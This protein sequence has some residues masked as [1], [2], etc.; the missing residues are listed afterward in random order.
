MEDSGRRTGAGLYRGGTLCGHSLSFGTI[1]LSLVIDLYVQ[2][3]MQ[4][5]CAECKVVLS[6]VR[7]ENWDRE[8]QY[9][10]R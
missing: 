8:A 6:V 5:R 4:L 9:A 3:G 7:S 10:K 2:L 1:I